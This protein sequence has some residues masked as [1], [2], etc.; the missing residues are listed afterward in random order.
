[1][2]L[3]LV[4]P[5]F[6][7]YRRSPLEAVSSYS[8]SFLLPTVSSVVYSLPAAPSVRCQIF[9]GFWDSRG[10]RGHQRGKSG[11]LGHFSYFWLRS[12]QSILS[13]DSVLVAPQ[14]KYFCPTH[15]PF[16]RLRGSVF[17]FSMSSSVSVFLFKYGQ[18]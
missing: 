1:M 3:S 12:H 15:P 13:V 16:L 7:L 8:S 2:C 9:F 6:S 10:S 11:D 17:P 5:S 14:P 18:S 4:R